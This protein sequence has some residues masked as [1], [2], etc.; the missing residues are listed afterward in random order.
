MHCPQT[1]LV[2]LL[3]C[4]GVKVTEDEAVAMDG[5]AD[6]FVPVDVVF[7][8]CI[9]RHVLLFL[10]LKLVPG[11]VVQLFFHRVERQL[12]NVGGLVGQEGVVRLSLEW[13]DQFGG[14]LEHSGTAR[15][16]HHLSCYTLAHVDLVE[17]GHESL[18]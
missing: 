18:V 4:K 5:Y 6:V 9:Q 7:F 13:R 16:H 17:K 14:L 1:I 2:C 15:Q 10:F 3:F 12:L 11:Y 8:E